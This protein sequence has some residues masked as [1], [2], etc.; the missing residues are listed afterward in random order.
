MEGIGGPAIIIFGMT[1]TI[2]IKSNYIAT[3]NEGRVTYEG[4]TPG[5]VGPRT[6]GPLVLKPKCGLNPTG[7]NGEACFGS[8]RNITVMADIVINGCLASTDC[9]SIPPKMDPFSCVQS[10]CST[11]P[12]E[13]LKITGNY[14]GYLRLT[15]MHSYA[16][17]PSVSQADC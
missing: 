3:T 11:F 10:Y 14:H 9:L 15:S 7:E 17:I 6:Y 8:P 4:Q 5:S 1:N 13:G 16:T 12:T 2:T